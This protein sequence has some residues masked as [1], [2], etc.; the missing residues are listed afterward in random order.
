MATTFIKV[1]GLLRVDN[2]FLV[3]MLKYRSYAMP[4]NVIRIITNTGG[5]T[6]LFI[7]IKGDDEKPRIR[8]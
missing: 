2:F 3:Q 5:A 4:T 7:L 6:V 1:T 8:A